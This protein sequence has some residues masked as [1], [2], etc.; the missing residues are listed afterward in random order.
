MFVDYFFYKDVLILEGRKKFSFKIEDISAYITHNNTILIKRCLVETIE[1]CILIPISFNILNKLSQIGMW[2]NACL[3]I[4]VKQVT[5]FNNK[6]RATLK[7]VLYSKIH[8]LVINKSAS[9]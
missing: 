5:Y 6:V 8:L 4:K 1:T 9:N 3:T 2:Y 7:N